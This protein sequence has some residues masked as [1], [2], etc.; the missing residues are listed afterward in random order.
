MIS[1]LVLP[2]SCGWPQV[3]RY[4]LKRICSHADTALLL[5]TLHGVIPMVT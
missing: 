1:L 5:S 4:L 2:C 3:M